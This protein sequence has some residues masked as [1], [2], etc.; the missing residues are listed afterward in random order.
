MISSTPMP[1]NPWPHD[2]VLTIEDGS[3]VLLELL[4]IRE[5][6]GLHV[7]GDDLPPRLVATP[8]LEPPTDDERRTWSAAWP[9]LWRACLAHAAEDEDRTLVD[10]LDSA[11]PGAPER[12]ALLAELSGPSWSDAFGDDAFTSG[13]DAWRTARFDEQMEPSRLRRQPERDALDALVPAWRAGLRRVVVIPCAGD[14]TRRVR[15]HGLLVTAMTR[16]DPDAYGK[17]LRSF[18]QTV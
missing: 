15:E 8:E 11:P 4:W 18:T 1:G 5:A 7:D 6:R 12:A 2:M 17:A 13:H 9:A 3:Q 10:R 16:D 14:A